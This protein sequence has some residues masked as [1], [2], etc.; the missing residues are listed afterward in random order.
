LLLAISPDWLNFHVA[1]DLQDKPSDAA[2][3][4]S[5]KFVD[6][7]IDMQNSDGFYFVIYPSLSKDWGR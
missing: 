6:R 5:V 3:E 2:I 7:C 1:I 4:G